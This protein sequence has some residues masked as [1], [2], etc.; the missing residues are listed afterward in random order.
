MYRNDGSI[1]KKM[2]RFKLKSFPLTKKAMVQHKISKTKTR[3]YRVLKNKY[4]NL[5]LHSEQIQ[6]IKF[7]RANRNHQTDNNS[8]SDRYD[9]YFRKNM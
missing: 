1:E 5:R 6:N 8:I 2:N 9:D 7:M 3:L 4:L